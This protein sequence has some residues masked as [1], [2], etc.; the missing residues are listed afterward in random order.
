[1]GRDAGK[2]GPGT[3]PRAGMRGARMQGAGMI[4]A[5]LALGLLSASTV[6]TLVAFTGAERGGHAAWLRLTAVD[7]A[8]D[9]AEQLRATGAGTAW[10]A[11]AWR[12][13]VASQLPDGVATAEANA[14]GY[15]LTLRWM[16]RAS[17]SEQQLMQQ[18][19]LGAAP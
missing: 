13:S 3:A 1:M 14:Q 10:D 5:L 19:L 8:A 15:R 18:V 12:A 4:E 11:A 16:D 7:L 2:K 17:G 6:G 9:A